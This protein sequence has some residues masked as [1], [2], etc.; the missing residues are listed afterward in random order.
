MKKEKSSEVVK[1]WMGMPSAYL[2]I[3]N[4]TGEAY[5]G[6]TTNTYFAFMR[7]KGVG[8]G[9]KWVPSA[10]FEA[11]QKYGIEAFSFEPE[12]CEAHERVSLAEQHQSVWN[13]VYNRRKK[14]DSILQSKKDP[15]AMC[16][17]CGIN[18]VMSGDFCGQLCY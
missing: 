7:F 4:E 13:C 5:S 15:N 12:L 10:I 17:E 1:S 9:K 11:I 18:Q 14:H 6:I 2:I 16:E 8:N 3:R